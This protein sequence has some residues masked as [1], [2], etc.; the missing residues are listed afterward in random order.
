MPIEPG[1]LNV[2]RP[3]PP[4]E[5]PTLPAAPTD[6]SGSEKSPFLSRL[7]D[8]VRGVNEL[9]HVADAAVE[10]L[11]TGD[12]DNVH[13]VAIALEKADLALQLTVQVTQKAVE[14]YREISR[15]QV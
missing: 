2:F 1:R 5:P 4:A 15:M 13:D 9:Q 14:A 10:S 11:A 12:A 8:A 3:L 6:G 7:T